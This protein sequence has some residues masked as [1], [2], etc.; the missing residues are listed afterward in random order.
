AAEA[1]WLIGAG[2]F[3]DQVQGSALRSMKEPGTAYDDDVLGRDPQPGHMDDYVDTVEDNGG[4]HHYNSGIPNRAFYLAATAIG[5]SS[6]EGA[7]Q[8]RYDALPGT[9]ITPRIDFA[10]FARLTVAA[11]G[12]RFGDGS[13]RQQAVADAWQQVGVTGSTGPVDRPRSDPGP[14]TGVRTGG[15]AGIR[16]ERTGSATELPEPDARAWQELLAD[17]SVRQLGRPTA[18]LP[19]GFVYTVRVPAAGIEWSAG[20]QDL[21]PRVRDLLHRFLRR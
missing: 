5:G 12:V 10:G 18:P 2:L 9:G 13:S 1:D 21:D 19:D 20:E 11:A 14:I 3:T 16:Q 15:F 17:R 4:V 7:G 6:W 8:V